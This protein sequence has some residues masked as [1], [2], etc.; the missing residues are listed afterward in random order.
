[1]AKGLPCRLQAAAC[2]QMQRGGRV[3]LRVREFGVQTNLQKVW[4]AWASQRRSNPAKSR[5]D[6]TAALFHCR[7]PHRLQCTFL[8]EMHWTSFTHRPMENDALHT[9]L[10]FEPAGTKVA[11]LLHPMVTIQ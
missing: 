1:M 8:D 4:W 7:L 6:A 9:S 5:S 10:H 3:P 11:D 2:W